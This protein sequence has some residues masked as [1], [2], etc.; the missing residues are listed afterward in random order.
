MRP[1]SHNDFAIAVICALPV[2][3]DA[4]EALF[5]KTYD[6]LGRFYGKQPGGTNA[7]VN[8][9]I[10]QHNVVLCYMP[11]MGKESAASV[12]ST[13]RTSYTES[14]LPWLLASVEKHH[15]RHLGSRST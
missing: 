8:G 10:G 14:R 1:K 5:D 4:V 3:A 11:G 9:R 2:E 6:R 12:A 13:L 7:Y 15:R